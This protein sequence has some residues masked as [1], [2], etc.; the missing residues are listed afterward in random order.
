M[1]FGSSTLGDF[2]AEP[3]TVPFK[4]PKRQVFHSGDSGSESLR[5]QVFALLDRNPLLTPKPL[6][7]LLN[8]PY[9]KYWRYMSNLRREW[10]YHYRNERGSKC[11]IHAWRGWCY[12]PAI[13]DRLKALEVGWVA[14]KAR[15]RWLLWK[16]KL[17][18]LQ[19][20]ETGRVNLYVRKPANLGRAYQLV[21]NGFSFTGLITDV[22]VLEEVLAGVRFKGAHYVFDTEQRLPRLVVDL[23]AK[24]NG[25]IVKVGD[26]SHPNAVEVVCCY[27]DWAERNERMLEDLRN[28]LNNGSYE[29]DYLKR[30]EYL[31]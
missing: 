21:C 28:L 16:D 27:P 3:S 14:S 31:V 2:L 29:K 10:K 6:C 25:I 4:S 13:A 18:R 19:W 20:F 30:L 9:R 12:V 8:L 22:K 24:S 11:S 23:F 26:T 17:G 1:V 5:Q 15:N 7:K